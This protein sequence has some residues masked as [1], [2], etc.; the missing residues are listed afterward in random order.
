MSVIEASAMEVPVVVTEYPGPSSGM[1]DGVT[2][3]S[4]A[5]HDSDGLARAIAEL[6]ADKEKR[7]AMG[8]AGRTFVEQNFEQKEFIRR[9]MG[10]RMEL[11]EGTKRLNGK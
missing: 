5:V 7:T 2:G 10:N 3:V 1:Q 11:L 8:C 9:Y 6:L 4:V